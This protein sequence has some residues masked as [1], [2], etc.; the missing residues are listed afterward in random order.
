MTENMSENMEGLLSMF[1]SSLMVV[2]HII[3]TVS[4]LTLCFHEGQ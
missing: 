1:Y 4:I 3:I 2:L